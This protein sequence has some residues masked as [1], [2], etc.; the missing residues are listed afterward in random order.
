M[1]YELR[2]YRVVQSRMYALS[3]WREAPF[4]TARDLQLSFPRCSL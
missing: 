2:V 3:A 4:F 1:I